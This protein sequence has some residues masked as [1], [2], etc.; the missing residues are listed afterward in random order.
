MKNPRIF[1]KPTIFLFIF[2]FIACS[3]SDETVRYG[4]TTSISGS[5]GGNITPATGTFDSGE[6][7]TITATP[8]EGYE[9]ESW[10][11]S[12]S[13]T[14]NPLK[15]TIASNTQV[16]A[17]FIQIDTDGDGV[18]DNDD[19]CAD[20]PQGETV[21]EFGCGDSQKD[22]DSDG[23]SDDI[24]E[25]PNTVSGSTV[26]ANGCEVVTNEAGGATDEENTDEDNTDGDGTD[27]EE[28]DDEDD[29]SD[30]DANEDE[31]VTDNENDEDDTTNGENGT[32]EPEADADSDGDGISDDVDNCADTPQGETVDEL[33]CGE[34]QKDNDE[35]GIFNN[36]DI[37][38]DT[39]TGEEADATGCSESQKDADNDSINDNLDNCPETPAG[40]TVDASGCGNS[41]KDSDNDGVSDATDQCPDTAAGVSVD[42]EGCEIVSTTFV[43]D[44][45]FEQQL[46]DLGYDTILDNQVPTSSIE[47]V[48]SLSLNGDSPPN[49]GSINDLTGLEA[50]VSL[51]NLTLGFV[52]DNDYTLDTSDFPELRELSFF[53]STLNSIIID[54]NSALESLADD[55]NLTGTL[56]VTNNNSLNE[57]NLQSAVINSVLISGT[58]QLVSFTAFDRSIQ[59]ITIIDN[60]ALQSIEL[61]NVTFGAFDFSDNPV[62]ESF[63]ISIS[64]NLPD[65]SDF[66]S[67][68]NLREIAISGISD[69][70]LSSIDISS[71]VLL[72]RL[73]IDSSG[74]SSLDIS[75]NN[76]LVTL[77]ADSNP[78]LTCIKVNQAQLENIPFNWNKDGSAS[79]A[80][81]CP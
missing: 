17:S 31:D 5:E 9:F 16:T 74:F 63:G 66:S 81:D 44:D 26:T 8:S 70:S 77:Y 35:D 57:I 13:G 65:L 39:P 12:V 20:T 22:S 60:S 38:G 58:T 33:G 24:D 61:L 76:I 45:N 18:G 6:S 52:D 32:P 11:G 23:V 19:D 14:T 71:N 28:T 36:D 62:L 43:P 51:T 41:Q 69:N 68:P 55:I 34:S 54:E 78:N 50:F 64:S 42:T 67:C 27:E 48:E 47:S 30:E 10:G 3:K 56:E 2:I 59:S 7:I 25:C 49:F 37:C 79:Y 73:D 72:E 53:E 46:I 15:I 29:E 40:E 80:L 1:Y 75:N 4:L 21:D